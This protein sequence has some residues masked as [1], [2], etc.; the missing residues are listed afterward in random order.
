MTL[1][2]KCFS[3]SVSYLRGLLWMR[4]PHVQNVVDFPS[5]AIHESAGVTR[6]R[7]T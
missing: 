2:A 7:K 6:N 5:A 4:N 1:I 3:R